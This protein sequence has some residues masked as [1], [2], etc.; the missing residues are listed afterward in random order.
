MNKESFLD[1]Y[2]N[3]LPVSSSTSR[4]IHSHPDFFNPCPKEPE[5]FLMPDEDIDEEPEANMQETLSF[6]TALSRMSI[7]QCMIDDVVANRHKHHPFTQ[8]EQHRPD[9]KFK[10]YYMTPKGEISGPLSSLRMDDLFRLQMLDLDVRLKNWC[11]DQ[12]FPLI[13]F[14]RRYCRIYK[15]HNLHIENRPKR[16][17]NKI[18]KFKKGNIVSQR[19]SLMSIENFCIEVAVRARNK[20]Q[21]PPPAKAIKNMGMERRRNTV[22][23]RAVTRV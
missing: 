18:L 5:N 10:W 13:R 1:C 21:A 14:I 9:T 4:L 20:T 12:Y 3:E 23:G 22:R 2:F 16:V 11:D 6:Y 17:S 15:E 8:I 19:K 7:D